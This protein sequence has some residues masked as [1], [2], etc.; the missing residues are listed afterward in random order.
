[1][2]NPTSD[3][4]AIEKLAEEL[5]VMN[6]DGS[7]ENARNAWEQQDFFNVS[8]IER[9]H[10][11]KDANRLLGVIEKLGYRKFHSDKGG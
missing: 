3:P 1:M 8:L 2:L 11:R 10:W 7:E 9:E 6:W 5:L 4:E